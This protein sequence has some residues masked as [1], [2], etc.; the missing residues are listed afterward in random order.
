[1]KI[2][3]TELFIG[4][5]LAG[6]AGAAPLPWWDNFPRM[7]IT[8]DLATA[9]SY[10]ANA[11]AN[12]VANDPGWGLWF[13][14][15][16]GDGS[17]DA[18]VRQ[19]FQAAGIVSLSYNESFG[20]VASPIVELQFD[21][22]SQRWTPRYSHWNWQLYDGGPIVWGGA[23]TW[24]DS[25]HNDPPLINN[26]PS[27]FARPYTRQHSVYGGPPMTYPDG[28]IATGF[29]DNDS[30]DPRKSRVYDA[31]S[32]KDVFG[33]LQPSYGYNSSAWASNQPHA[34]EIYVPATGRF[35]GFVAFAKD[36]ACP[37]WADYASASTRAAAHLSGAQGTWTDNLGA[38]DSFM[39]GGP[40]AS[41]FG[42]WSVARFR[43]YL[44]NHF[45]LAQ[46]QSWGVLQTNSILADLA[47]F[48]VRAYFRT[49]AS[50]QF[51]LATT[52][53]SDSAWN[54]SGW[55]DQPIWRAYK[56]FKRQIGTEALAA[57]DQAVHNAAAQGG[58]PDF[59]LLANDI[60]PACFAWAR[61]S[62]DLSSTEL[63]LGWNL[64]SGER[65]FGLPPFARIAPLYKTA[66]EHGRSRF[67]GVWLY[68]D[69]YEAAL[70]NRG[71]VEALF[72]EMLATHTL[73]HIAAGDTHWA[74]TPLVQTNFLRF[75]SLTA[76][77]AFVN[78]V[79]LEEIGI[80]FSSSSI[81]TAALP[82]DAS[83]F[84]KQDHMFALWG[85]GTALSEL[86]YQYRMVPEWKLTRDFLGTLK[87]L[88]VPNAVA[89][90]GPDVATL[91]DW[92]QTDGGS[93]IVTG[94]SG[95]RLGESGNFDAVTNLVLSPLTA[96]TN[97]N[98]APADF[99]NRLGAGVVRFI[100]S[101]LGRNYYDASA[102]G[103][104]AQRAMLASVLSNAFSLVGA[105]PMLI[106]SNA[107]VTVG[108]T[109]YADPSA[110]KSFVDLNNFN[111]DPVTFSTT[112]TPELD[113]DLQKP[114]WLGNDVPLVA[115][116]ISPQS[117]ISLPPPEVSATGIHLHLPSVTNYLS[118]V[119]QAPPTLP[120]ITT[121]PG[122]QTVLA[123]SPASFT[124]N[125][126]GSA[127]LICQ[128]K[129]YGTNLASATNSALVLSQAQRTNSG[130]YSV[131]V[132]NTHGGT[133]SSNA[134]LT[135]AIPLELRSPQFSADGAFQFLA[136]NS[137]CFPLAPDEATNYEALASTDLLG[138]T[139]LYNV[140]TWSNSMLILKDPE[141]TNYSKRF[142]RLLQNQE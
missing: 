46:L 5:L 38:W 95:S 110:A 133:L 88:I 64:A 103:R 118:I 2:P 3:L 139:R 54:N 82:G 137:D 1:V 61:G 97:Y 119:L 71:P 7:I 23:W 134:M 43:G 66:R 29:F 11:A 26:E 20:D 136:A 89:F 86:H 98:T 72:Y 80:Y 10:S 127:P 21:L 14:Y 131:A 9:Q 130:V 60:T 87:V 140:L 69:G 55:L 32:S 51:G 79:P 17:A 63:S 40:V 52:N 112:P 33:H 44:T 35:A 141:A 28:T 65:G 129:F 8:S 42:E 19:N 47:S 96:V 39:S 25:F 117:G 107:P 12:G 120:T 58:Q 41:A 34:G 30:T 81:L 57:Y 18:S 101:N 135:V 70:T 73:P 48:D 113:V 83:D 114:A 104:S 53:L 76:A 102:A 94:G 108:L 45:T 36:S 115:T 24:F 6:S 116:A 62:F 37:L 59:A 92:V 68:T 142:Y 75:V 111:V 124:V 128:W 91:L 85:W 122:N 77:P 67:V 132:T 31:G 49:V 93:L 50:N 78:R 100:R 15:A 4:G 138:W 109:M 106:S 56:I 126:R 99:T 74:G 121:Q 125:V 13:N 16:N 123:G 22:A 84:S 27:Y 90:E 105:Q